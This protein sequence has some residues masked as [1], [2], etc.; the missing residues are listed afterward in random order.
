M[1]DVKIFQIRKIQRFD[2]CDGYFKFDH[3]VLMAIKVVR[4]DILNNL[5]LDDISCPCKLDLFVH[6]DI[7][8][9]TFRDVGS[10]CTV[11]QPNGL[12]Q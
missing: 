7:F 1:A 12:L 8:I 3:S 10:G 6:V 9:G 11:P 2:K 4:N 5:Y